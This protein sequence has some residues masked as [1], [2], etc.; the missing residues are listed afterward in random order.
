MR[1]AKADDDALRRAEQPSLGRIARRAERVRLRHAKIGEDLGA[2]P[3]RLVE[4]A[5]DLD[6]GER[7]GRRKQCGQ[8]TSGPR[9]NHREHFM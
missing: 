6:F 7:A 3:F 2:L 4:L 8:Q 5:V 9:S 1:A